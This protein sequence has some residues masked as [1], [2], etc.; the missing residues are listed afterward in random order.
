M[1][2]TGVNTRL[3][4]GLVSRLAFLRLNPPLMAL[5]GLVFCFCVQVQTMWC[6]HL[7][8]DTTFSK[9][10]DTPPAQP[11]PRDGQKLFSLQT[12]SGWTAR[13]VS[14]YSVVI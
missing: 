6:G 2:E 13:A 5:L 8:V 1:R 3:F 9:N 10:P 12:C 7:D 11:F 4:A 14:L